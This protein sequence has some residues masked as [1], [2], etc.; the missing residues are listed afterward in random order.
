MHRCGFLL[1]ESSALGPPQTTKRPERGHQHVHSRSGLWDTPS[2]P[3]DVFP[4]I[5]NTVRLSTGTTTVGQSKCGSIPTHSA[6]LEEVQTIAFPTQEHQEGRVWVP[7]GRQLSLTGVESSLHRPIWVIERDF[8][9]STFKIQL[10]SGQETVS[11]SRLKAASPVSSWLGGGL[12]HRS[13]DRAS[14]SLVLLY[15]NDDP[16]AILSLLTELSSWQ[17]K[18][19]EYILVLTFIKI[20][21][22]HFIDSYNT[23]LNA[24]LTPQLYNEKQLWRHWGLNQHPPNLQA[25]M[26]ATSPALIHAKTIIFEGKFKKE[27]EWSLAH[28]VNSFAFKEGKKNI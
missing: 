28:L 15:S 10:P 17:L 12:L 14:T 1:D 21:L 13:S 22:F 24:T 6:R 20:E 8:K 9:N 5:S 3:W 11:L 23:N 2:D 16:V 7:Q 4:Q 27:G 18:V 25:S 26:P 19:S